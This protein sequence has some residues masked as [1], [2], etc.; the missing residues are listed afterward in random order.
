MDEFGLTEQEARVS[1]HLEEAEKLLEELMREGA[2][3]SGTDLLALIIWRETHVAEH[4]RALHRELA[5]RV[6]RRNYPEGWGYV[7]P[8]DEDQD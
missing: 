4:F 3:E 5:M 6:L 8:E 7:P 1:I 2:S